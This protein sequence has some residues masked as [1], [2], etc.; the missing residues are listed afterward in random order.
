MGAG[1]SDIKDNEGSVYPQFLKTN[2]SIVIISKM[3]SV[4]NSTEVPSFLSLPVTSLP[5]TEETPPPFIAAQPIETRPDCPICMLPL[6]F[7]LKESRYMSCCGK[8]LCNGCDVAS[9]RAV[10]VLTKSPS[11]KNNCNNKI[12]ELDE[13]MMIRSAF[14]SNDLFPAVERL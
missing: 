9:K 3:S 12:A 11:I 2:F 4:H 7:H 10:A 6:P 5:S 14:N 13:F 8:I 1:E